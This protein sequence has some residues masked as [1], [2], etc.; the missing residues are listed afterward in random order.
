[1][2]EHHIAEFGRRLGMPDLALDP[3]G[4]LSLAVDGLGIL[5]LERGPGKPDAEDE[6]LLQAALP[7]PPADADAA[8]RV[9]ARCSWRHNHPYP[10]A[11]GVH[12]DQLVLL[13]RFPEDA[14][15][16]SL[17][18]NAFRF[19]LEQAERIVRAE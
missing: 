10:L 6:L 2:L 13:T 18:E 7:L 3:E 19:L 12:R 4:L 5:T 9:L 17:L 14:V 11:G 15:N 16:A 8:R 1:M